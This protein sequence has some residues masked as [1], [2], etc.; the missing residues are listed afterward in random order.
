MLKMKKRKVL[1]FDAFEEKRIDSGHALRG[2]YKSRPSGA[3]SIDIVGIGVDI[4]Q[5]NLSIM[6]RDGLSFDT[7]AKSA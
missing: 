5:E 6:G 4:R 1:P 2:G 7:Q 3:A